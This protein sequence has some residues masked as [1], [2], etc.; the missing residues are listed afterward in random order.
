[1]KFEVIK[2]EERSD[3][4]GNLYKNIKMRSLGVKTETIGGKQYT[5]KVPTRET[6]FNAWKESY[7]NQQQEYGF[8]AVAGQ[9]L[10]QGSMITKE[11][12]PYQIADKKTGKMR[13]VTSAT[14]L[15]MGIE[16]ENLTQ[17]AIISAFKS[18]NHILL[19]QSVQTT[20]E[21]TV[22]AE[23]TPAGAEVA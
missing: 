22:E 18:S 4:N 6:S 23:P 17:S 7:L 12:E 10:L 16:E 9:D 11:V 19:N 20:T 5:I 8:D 3:G 15:I 2:T 13:S 21:K 1:M 14:V